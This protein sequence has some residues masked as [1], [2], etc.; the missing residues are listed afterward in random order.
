MHRISLAIFAMFSLAACAFKSE[1]WLAERGDDSDM[2]RLRAAYSDCVAK[3]DSPAE[4]VAIPLEYHSDGTVK[5]RL[6]AKRAQ[7]FLDTDF[8]WGEG[9]LVAQYREDGSAVGTIEA[10]NCV[11][12]RKTRT[13]W[14]EGVAKMTYGDSMVKGRGVYFSLEREFIK[15]FSQSEIRTKGFNDRPEKL[16]K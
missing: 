4:N 10:E 12:D 14:V 3:I 7:L 16:L 5:S 11:V 9:I 6:T 13:G 2:L 1:K 15:I 8:I